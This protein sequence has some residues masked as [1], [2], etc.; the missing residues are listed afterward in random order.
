MPGHDCNIPPS[1]S[2]LSYSGPVD[3]EKLNTILRELIQAGE[4]AELDKVTG[5]RVYAIVVEIL[6]NIIKY[7]ESEIPTKLTGEPSIS[8]EKKE[9]RIFIKAGNTVRSDFARKIIRRIEEV[10]NL[11]ENA[12]KDLYEKRINE[13]SKKDATGAGLGLILIRLKS[14]Y[15]ISYSLKKIENDLDFLEITIEVDNYIR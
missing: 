14:G 9:E 15:E 10:N 12:L 11:R 4:F 3:Y 2:F 8:V 1:G 13:E 7:S 6:E 5:K